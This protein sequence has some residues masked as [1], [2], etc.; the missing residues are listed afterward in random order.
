[1]ECLD[2]MEVMLDFFAY[3]SAQYAEAR[4]AD[5]TAKNSK[6]KDH[7]PENISNQGRKINCL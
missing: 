3:E 7:M 5:L 4:I 1:M 2:F 6:F